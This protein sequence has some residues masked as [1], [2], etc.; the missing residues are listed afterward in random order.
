MRQ[1]EYCYEGKLLATEQNKKLCSCREGLIFAMN[2]GII[3]E[4]MSYLCDSDRRLRVHLGEFEG[5]IPDGECIY[6][7]EGTRAKEI[8]VISRV[9]KPVCFM[10]T[11]IIDGTPILSRAK[12]QKECHAK[13]L[14]FLC[15]GDVIEAKITRLD[16]FGA[17]CDIGCGII[18]LL[19]IDCMSVSRISHPRDRFRNGQVIKAVVKNP[20]DE[21]GRITLTH[22]ELLGTWEENAY[23][24]TPGQ[25]AAGIV[26]SVEDYGIFVELTPNLAGLA[27]Y[28]DDVTV[29]Q[30]A[31]VYIKNIIKNRMKVKL[32]II[33]SA[34]CS[35]PASVYE[36][37]E[38]EH[39]SRWKYSPD[40]C[41]KVIESVF[42]SEINT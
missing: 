25:T 4:G 20:P 8:A 9:G 35:C 30:S 11:D 7:H 42:D 32:A 10:V 26:R 15:A 3:L 33:D 2:E 22:R 24:F 14:S 17:F 34:D 6:T 29:G 1:N 19:P 21:F 36:Y 31:A 13:K 28:R 41:D 40:C 27:E 38:I 39:I 18:S 23:R 16:P 5:I 12:A 37:P